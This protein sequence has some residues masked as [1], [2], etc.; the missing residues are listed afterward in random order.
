MMLSST[1]EAGEL[2]IYQYP[3]KQK[4]KGYLI[5]PRQW[6]KPHIEKGYNVAQNQISCTQKDP[7]LI[8][9]YYLQL[10]ASH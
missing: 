8:K 5:L 1:E 7:A 10:R 3:L 2:D 9:Q 6:Y 4:C